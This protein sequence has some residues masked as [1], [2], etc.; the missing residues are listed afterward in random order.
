MTMDSETLVDY[1]RSLDCIHCG[2]CL[3]TCPTYQLTGRE[4]SSPRGRI[5]LMRAVAEDRIEA[6]ADFAEEM[7]FC[8]V[9]RHC[10]SVCPAGV[11]F[12][13]MMEFTRDALATRARPGPLARLARWLGFRVVLPSRRWLR[14]TVTLL[15]LAQRT[16][17][18]RIAAPLLG[19]RG[20]MLAS[21]PRVPSR[22][23]R[24]PLPASTPAQGP[25]RESAAVLEGCV[26]PELY[27]RVNRATVRS[28]AAAGVES[29]C[30]P[31]HVCCGALHAHN[32]DLAGARTLARGT[33][34]AFDAL[35]DDSGAPLPIVVNSAGCGA[36]MKEYGRLLADDPEWRERAAAFGAR[37]RDFAEFLAEPER[38][39]RL[40]AAL[41]EAAD[42]APTRPTTYDDPCHLCHGQG[43]RSEP[44]A[45]LDCIPGV[46]LLE[47][48]DAESCCGSAG[49]YSLLRPQDSQDV[50]DS[51]LAA[52]RA[53]G[54]EVLVTANPGC[55]L[56]WESGIRRAAMDVEVVHLAE[57]VARAIDGS[58]D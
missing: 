6:N 3:D 50:L 23:E 37:T 9:C 38:R 1:A 8:L 39:E 15:G 49:I 29:R 24:T 12:G 47:L 25:A 18:L 32:G 14:L 53:S 10:E 26:M 54:A 2:L 34:A 21:F 31:D 36:H 7:D 27:G 20:R 17:A 33:I 42:S 48:E 46:E 58:G 43:I 13:A 56:Q 22:A 5:H 51:K 45:L 4:S 19:L 40:T 52:L 16:G 57:V 55:Q 44:R 35:V 30:A 41:R 11:E 28:L